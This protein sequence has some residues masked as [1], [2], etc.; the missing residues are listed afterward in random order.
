MSFADA[1]AQLVQAG[2]ADRILVFS[3][4]S[5]TVALAA[6]DIGCTEG[7]IC[8]TMAFDVE[9]RT[10]LV[11]M[12]GDARIDNH[13][14]KAFFHKKAVML[15]G[16]EL[17]KRTGHAAGGVCPFGLKESCEVYLDVSMKRFA[18]VYP[19]CGSSTSAVRLSLDEL[20]QLSGSRG[21][22]DVTS[23]QSADHGGT[24]V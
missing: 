19:A 8:K 11:C 10:V 24:G 1:Q 22:V 5:A 6:R 13:K 7:E 23:F 9:G 4:S 2:M 3:S 20:V 12:A 21:W 17:E 15:K 14:Y 16:E 18:Q